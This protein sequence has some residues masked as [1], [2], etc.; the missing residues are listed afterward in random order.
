MYIYGMEGTTR[1]YSLKM[2]HDEYMILRNIH[3]EVLSKGFNITLKGIIQS[4]ID[5]VNEKGIKEEDFRF[6]VKNSRKKNIVEECQNNIR[7]YNKMQLNSKLN[8]ELKKIFKY[9]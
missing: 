6:F 1:N 7:G 8:V 4:C 5:M 3:T 2:N 9:D